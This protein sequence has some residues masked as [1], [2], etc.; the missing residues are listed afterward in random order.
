MKLQLVLRLFIKG[1]R[2]NCQLTG[3]G[4]RMKIL[5]LSELLYP[6]G[7]G[8]ELATHL[9]TKSLSEDDFKITVV[10]HRFERE[11]E[12]SKVE[13][14]VIYR[15]PLLKSES[16]SKYSVLSRVDILLSSFMN[17]L[18]HSA[19]MVYVP[20]FWYSGII[21]A[22]VH[23]KPVVTHVHDYIPVCSLSNLC[24]PSTG[25]ICDHGT[26]CKPSCIYSFEKSEGR[27][28]LKVVPS[29]L[30]NSTIGLS[31]RKMIDM[32]DAIVCVSKEQQRLIGEKMPSFL[33]KS[34]VI[35]NPL[36]NISTESTRGN[37]FGFFGGL[38]SLKGFNV[39]CKAL[40]KVNKDRRK[41]L[42]VYATK[43]PTQNRALVEV[44]GRLGFSV[45]GKLGNYAYHKLQ[46]QILGVVVPSIWPEPLPYVVTE[47]MLRKK[48]V[49]ASSIGGIP[50]QVSTSKGTF[51]VN[52]GDSTHLAEAFSKA[53]SLGSDE[54]ADAGA[55]NRETALRKF[56]NEKLVAEFSKLLRETVDLPG[57]KEN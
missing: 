41:P 18:I 57:A 36:P 51:L 3:S 20:R 12:Y 50:E 19:D 5:V 17:K 15:L 37:A 38:S 53:C 44:L 13:N 47:A 9:Y 31:F 48:I 27:N 46:E 52:P 28:L 21:W 32:S 49:I 35:Y 10:T 30:L 43:F 7:G 6:H 24:N 39:L 45:H 8:A 2:S 55:N 22:K 42:L 14:L 4:E 16:Q 1:V 56:D 23:R 40:G 33:K 26:S 34:S 29:M 11:P 25:V 54:L